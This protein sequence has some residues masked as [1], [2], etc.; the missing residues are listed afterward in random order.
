MKGETSHLYEKK[1][2]SWGKKK[3]ANE[4]DIEWDDSRINKKMRAGW[5]GKVP[6]VVK[7]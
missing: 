2:P 6:E 1:I 3:K 7:L 5:R 4:L